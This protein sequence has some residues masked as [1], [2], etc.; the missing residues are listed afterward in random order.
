[1]GRIPV[2]RCRQRPQCYPAGRPRT[3]EQKSPC[4][5]IKNAGLVRPGVFL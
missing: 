2:G 3:G 5:D 1:M 4:G